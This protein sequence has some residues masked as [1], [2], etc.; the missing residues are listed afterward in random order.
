[1]AEQSEQVK[2]L[3]AW[4]ATIRNA[5]EPSTGDALQQ[6]RWQP[7]TSASSSRSRVAPQRVEPVAVLP[8]REVPAPGSREA[9]I[10]ARQLELITMGFGSLRP[11][12][13][14]LFTTFFTHTN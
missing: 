12:P 1:M 8:L 9:L 11:P 14:P 7:N 2:P 13:F 5:T 4:A 3:P 6:P 10:S